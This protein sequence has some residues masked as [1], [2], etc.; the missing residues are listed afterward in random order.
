MLGMETLK[1]REVRPE[2]I[3]KMLQ[4][5]SEDVEEDILEQEWAPFDGQAGKPGSLLGKVC[6]MGASK[7]LEAALAA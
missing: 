5:A 2:H 6:F 4:Q 3:Q 7:A 1:F